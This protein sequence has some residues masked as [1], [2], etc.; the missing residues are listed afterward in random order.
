[1]SLLEVQ[2][3]DKVTEEQYNRIQEILENI[4]INT[5][6][7]M[8]RKKSKQ[9]VQVSRQS[10]KAKITQSASRPQPKW[11][12]LLPHALR[13]QKVPETNKSNSQPE[14]IQTYICRII[15]IRKRIKLY[16]H[17]IKRTSCQNTTRLS[18]I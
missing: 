15:T 5:E 7:D 8:A 11:I 2:I 3:H 13:G 14:L 16:S 10:S 1:M 6:Q 17:T 12:P 18:N 4:K 9:I